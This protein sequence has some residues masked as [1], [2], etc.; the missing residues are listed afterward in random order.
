VCIMP[1]ISD[2]EIEDMNYKDRMDQA[3][4]LFD[5]ATSLFKDND[6][7]QCQSLLE[8]ALRYLFDVDSDSPKSS[9]A[10]KSAVRELVQKVRLSMD[11]LSGI[12]LACRVITKIGET[13][14][15][16]LWRHF[17]VMWVPKLRVKTPHPLES[18]SDL[19][20]EWTLFALTFLRLV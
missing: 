13:F 10:L 4:Q 14:A 2:E 8:E 3:S 17:V 9:Q 11:C 19:Q 6:M 7:G 1:P 20:K 15:C 12:A 5:R 16:R 18:P